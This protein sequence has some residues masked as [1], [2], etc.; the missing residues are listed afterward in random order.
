MVRKTKEEAFQTR[1]KILDAAVNL[2]HEQGIAQTS[3]GEIAE[4]AGVT[5]GAI[6][7][8]FKDKLDIFTSIHERYHTSMIEDLQA[9]LETNPG[10]PLRKL[11]EVGVKMLM[12]LDTNKQKKLL[13]RMFSMQCAYSG[14]M[15]PFLTQQLENKKQA[16]SL[17][18]RFFAKAIENGQ[19]R[20]DADPDLL[21]LS[22]FCYVCGIANEYLRHGQLF[23]L[24]QNASPLLELFFEK[25]S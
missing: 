16:L 14:D 3:L 11:K 18:A 6:Y 13:L 4:K 19:I 10:M 24:K 21:S 15:S 9:T 7:W 25:I 2:F 17:F 8:H 20:K 12:E 1:E 5:R 22:F 23:D